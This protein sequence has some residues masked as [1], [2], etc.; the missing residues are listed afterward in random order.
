M[1]VRVQSILLASM[2]ALGCSSDPAPMTG[3]DAA[4]DAPAADAPAGDAAPLPGAALTMMFGCRNCHQ[5]MNAA[6]GLLSGQTSPRPMTMAY[7]SN[8][9]P[10]MA[11]GLGSWTEDQVVRAIREGMDE[12][13]R[14]LCRTMPRY[15]SLPTPMTVEQARMIAQYLRTLPAVNRM[16]PASMCP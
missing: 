6:D 1:N 9:T 2:F 11:T 8:L 10:D 16:I 3:T 4:A 13:G 14:T 7:G 5:S 15:G 12:T